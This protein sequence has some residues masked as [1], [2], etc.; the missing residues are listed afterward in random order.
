MPCVVDLQAELT[1]APAGDATR[2]RHVAPGSPE[3]RAGTVL[4]VRVW[5][6]LRSDVTEPGFVDA[7]PLAYANTGFTPD[8]FEARQRRL[9]VDR[10]VALRNAP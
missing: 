8:A 2:A 10:T 6:R 1:V 3:A 5:L 7:R 4:A 9:L